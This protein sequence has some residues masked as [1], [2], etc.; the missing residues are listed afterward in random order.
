MNIFKWLFGR[1]E[2][3]VEPPPE[4]LQAS[5]P[6]WVID[7]KGQPVRHRPGEGGADGGA[8]SIRVQITTATRTGMAE[9]IVLPGAAGGEPKTATRALERT[10]IDRLLVILGFSFPADI[11]AVT[12]GTDGGSRVNVTIHRREPPG[13]VAAECD[14][15]EWLESR[16]PG[17]PVVEIGRILMEIRRG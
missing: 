15:G 14:L 17:S 4:F 5:P 3:P 6:D 11:A 13:E 2:A 8:F 10:E 9:V 12:G 1:K 16:K 7:L